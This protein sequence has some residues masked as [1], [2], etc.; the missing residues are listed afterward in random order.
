[1][2]LKVNCFLK[3]K[4]VQGHRS[5]LKEVPKLEQLEEK[6]KI[7]IHEFIAIQIIS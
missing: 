1:M 2:Q 5:Q 4:E 7:N 6:N 3:N